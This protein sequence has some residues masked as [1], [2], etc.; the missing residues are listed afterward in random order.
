MFALDLPLLLRLVRR[1]CRLIPR[2]PRCEPAAAARWSDTVSDP[3]DAT[4][5]AMQTGRQTFLMSK[6]RRAAD[7]E[8]NCDRSVQ[9]G[10][11]VFQAA[12]WWVFPAP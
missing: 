3:P 7:R 11:T 1:R 4:N 12:D 2:F 5:A 8:A 10:P 6:L 9:N